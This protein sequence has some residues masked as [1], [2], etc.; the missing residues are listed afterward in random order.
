MAVLYLIATPIGNLEDISLR[1]LGILKSVDLILCE[2]TRITRKLLERYQIKKPLVSYHQHSRIKKERYI[3]EQL[4]KNKD[5]ALVSDAGTPTISD[6]GA[7]LIS[8][9]LEN[10]PDLEVI[11]IPGPCALIAA[12]SVSGF[13]ADKF[14]FL[15]FPPNKRKRK[16]F[17]K[18]IEKAKQTV[19]FYE[20]PH[21]IL[22]TLRELN[23]DLSIILCRELTKKFEIT[24][25][26]K[27]QEIIGELEKEKIRGEFVVVINKK[28]E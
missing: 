7:K 12:L 18:Q 4:E 24:Y 25:R 16:K 23:S 14:V 9:L 27:A 15:G 17:F 5:L 20:S 6:P 1:A 2:D 13:P 28:H 19:V 22:K 11:P 10:L 26:G 3:L 8:Y 21:R